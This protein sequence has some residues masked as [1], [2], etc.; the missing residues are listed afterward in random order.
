M[1]QNIKDFITIVKHK[2][3]ELNQLNAQLIYSN[4]FKYSFICSISYSLI[5]LII[6]L[7]VIRHLLFDHKSIEV[8]DQQ[9]KHQ[10]QHLL[11]VVQVLIDE[12]EFVFV[13]F[14]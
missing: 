1:Q 7:V 11:M 12:L 4:L 14:S 3:L 10:F 13:D 5:L 8:Y 2:D 9:D 6:L